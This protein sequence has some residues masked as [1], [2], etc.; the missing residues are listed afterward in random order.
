MKKIVSIALLS[1]YA[2]A[3]CSDGNNK[4]KLVGTW[5]ATSIETPTEDSLILVEKDLR[6][7]EID[8][9]TEVP[10]M[11]KEERKI[12]NLD[13]AKALAKQEI[14]TYLESREEDR[15]SLVETFQMTFEGNGKLY[16]KTQD[17]HDTAEWYL[18][19]DNQ[20]KQ[21]IVVDPFVPGKT[22]IPPQA[23]ITIFEVVHNSGDSLRLQFRQSEEY[24]MY[25]SLKKNK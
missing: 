20:G 7:K 17:I 4:S 12:S 5:K 8:S 25:I 10:Q 14:N 22:N 3:S 13:S 18:T 16:R 6:M 21:V 11:F 2:L 1:A 9:W 19:K 15:N 23:P 24:K